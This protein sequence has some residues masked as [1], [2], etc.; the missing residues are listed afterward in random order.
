MKP[1]KY[2]ICLPYD[3]RFVVFNGVT[4]RFFLVSSQNK[5]AFLRILSTPDEYKEQ[6]APFLKQMA[7]EGFIIEDDVDEL[8][9]IKQQYHDLTHDNSYK[10]MILPTYACN[11]SCW[12]CTQNHRNMQL[13]DDDIERVKKHIAYYLPHN[14]IK[15]F[16][17]AWFGGEPLLSFHRVEEIASF[18]KTFCQEH[19]IS[20][21]NTITTNGT[22]LSR[23]ILEKMK[24]L[25]FT[26]FQITVDGTKNEHDKVKVIKGKSAYE[27]S[28]RNICLISEILPD[29]EICLRY[30]YTTGNLKPDA[31][32]KD[33][34]QYLP[35]NIR[36][37][38]NLSVMK[39]WQED[40]NNI[41]EQKIDTLVNSASED[42]FQVS[43]GQ[44]FSPCYVDSLHFNS[45]FPNGRIGKCDNLDPEQAQ[46]HLTETGEIV[47]DKDIP[48]MHFSIF[49]DQES[50]CQS[51]KY[52]PICYGPCPKERNEVFLQG[53]HL[54]CRFAD[55]DRLW[56]LNIIYYC[57]HF[58]SICF[59]LLFSVGV[60]AQSN[61]SIYKSVELKDVVIKG[62][63]VVHYPDK[64]VWLITDSLRHN[65]YSVNE[66]VK[67]L[68][69]FQYSDAKDELSYLGS[70]NI[71]FLLDGKKKKGKYIG[72][73][74]N[75]RF[76]KI[77]IIE[78]PTGK[79]EDYQVVVNLI[80]K[81]N[82][83]GY[84]VRLSN[85][86][87]IRPSSP[88]DELLTSFNTSGTYTYTL[89]KY[90]IAVHYDYDHSNRHQQ[91]EYRT[92]NTSYIE[93]TIDNEKPTDIFYKNKH[94]FWIDTDFNLS[95]NHSI[96]FKYSLWKSASHTYF[97]KTV[98][99]LY[100]NDDKGY[101]VNVD[102]KQHYQGTQHIGTIAYQGKLKTWDFSSELTYEKLL[103]NQTNSYTENTQELY[104]TPFD[105]TKSYLFWDINAQNKIYRKAT[106]NMG[107]TTVRRKYESI[108][109]GTISET[110]SYR[111]SFY[112]S[113]S[114]SLNEKLRAKVGGQFKNIREEK[115]IQNILALNA[116]IEYHFNNNFFSD[117]YYRNQ[118]QFPNQQQLNTNGRW[119][120]SC[121]YMVGNPHLKAGTRHLADFL[122][123][124]PHVTFVSSFNYTGNGISQIYKDQ[125]GITLL[126]Y[127]NVKSWENSNSLFLQHSLNLS[128]GE[129][130]LKGYIKF[131]TS[132]SK[133][134]GN[135][136]KTSNWSGD[137]EVVYRM[138]NYPTISI[139]YAKAAY[140]QPS[141]QGWTTSGT[142]RCCL[143]IYQYMLNRK[144][145][146]NITYYIPISKGLNKYKEVYIETPTYSYYSSL[147]T[148]E[149]EKNM[150]TL[151]L[152]YR[153]AKGKQVNKRNTVQSIQN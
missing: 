118:T 92:K 111:H 109:Q 32:I 68:P 33:L 20:Y 12:Y 147:N 29:A 47:W 27:M 114:M 38:I 106:L 146:W 122:F 41:D 43:V 101:I 42:Q 99:R 8:E 151:S 34:E 71:L 24:D 129:L 113:F 36:K 153:F 74:A 136:Q 134:N 62:K 80:T 139:F 102:S 1:S 9:V 18:A 30:N 75:I 2:N 11:V 103:N 73:L 97:S 105:N 64:D 54:R 4:K 51:C 15:R 76:D 72:E 107:Y 5:E 46:G 57:R 81:D 96:S 140:K 138:K 82:W 6:Y 150:I 60:L 67:K 85:S 95:K 17:L 61:D 40:E 126:T 94:D 144:L 127:E 50:E 3:D 31:F 37:R 100:P 143:N 120:N 10:L 108:S 7:G 58:L 55:A 19:S 117:L 116:S 21:H 124:T 133:W 16:Q 112:A 49:D 142:D 13:S 48:A 119:I 78:H 104:Y 77:E 130:E 110:N 93:Q 86:D 53:N 89:P 79:Y 65:T 39:V 25:D 69:N 87:Y 149:E 56:N 44:G 125:G 35:E 70:N 91:Y 132:Y 90:D 84:D 88:Y 137:I 152:T 59:L 28:L 45:V 145:R 148:Y 121:L 23:R 14:D 128:K 22:L 123:T 141:A 26:F 115:D 66:L 98:E 131:I 83:K 63:N 52:L 135:T